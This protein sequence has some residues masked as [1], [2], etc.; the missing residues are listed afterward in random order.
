MKQTMNRK[1]YQRPQMRVVELRQRS[2]ILAGSNGPLGGYGT[3]GGDD[4]WSGDGG[5]GGSTPDGWT[6]NGGDAWQ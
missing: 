3:K 1:H 2:G 5:S 6:D 4:A